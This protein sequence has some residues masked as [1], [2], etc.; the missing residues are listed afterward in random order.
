MGFIAPEKPGVLVKARHRFEA[1]PSIARSRRPTEPQWVS[2][3]P[4]PTPWAEG[5]AASECD[6]E[7]PPGPTSTLVLESV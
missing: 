4:R 5:P 7:I 1:P 6:V 2:T 3:P